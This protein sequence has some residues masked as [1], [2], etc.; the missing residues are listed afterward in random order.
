MT[1]H[2]LINTSYHCRN[3]HPQGLATKVDAYD[4]PFA[5]SCQSFDLKETIKKHLYNLK[6]DFKIYDLEEFKDKILEMTCAEN[7]IVLHPSGSFGLGSK[8]FNS[9]KALMAFKKKSNTFSKCLAFINLFEKSYLSPQEAESK[10]IDTINQEIKELIENSKG[11]DVKSNNIFMTAQCYCKYMEVVSLLLIIAL[12]AIATEET[13]SLADLMDELSKNHDE[14]VPNNRIGPSIYD[15]AFMFEL[16]SRKLQPI[17]AVDALS[18]SFNELSVQNSKEEDVANDIFLQKP[19]EYILDEEHTPV[20]MPDNL[21]ELYFLFQVLNLKDPYP[22]FESEIS[23]IKKMIENKDLVKLKGKKR[24][25]SLPKKNMHLPK[26]ETHRV[27]K[28][29]CYLRDNINKDPYNAVVGGIFDS[30]LRQ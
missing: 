13:P 27:H 29:T 15:E 4:T 24:K 26:K 12:K 14:I 9:N 21:H 7:N 10:E 19:E 20:W 11:S 8:L 5:Q 23:D 17:E 6:I 1:N 22:K 16:L 2:Q 18:N 28:K 3:T 30:L 25:L